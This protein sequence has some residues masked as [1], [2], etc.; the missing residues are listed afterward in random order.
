MGHLAVIGFGPGSVE[1]C[2]PEVVEILGSATDWVGYD[3]YLDM[4][5]TLVAP[6]PGAV[7]HRTDNRQEG[8]RAR[9]ALDLAAGG[10]SVAVVSSGDPGVFAMAAA[11]LE[12]IER[13]P[14]PA[15][16][17][18]VEITV[19][20]GISAAQAAAA[21]AGAPL[22]HDFCVLSLSDNLKPWDL[23]ER[24]LDAVAAADLVIALYNPRSRH[25]PDQIGKAV[26][27]IGRHRG[28]ATPVVLGRDVGRP[29]EQV[30]ITTLAQLAEPDGWAEVDMRTVIIVGSSQTRTIDGPGGRTLAYTSRHHP[31]SAPG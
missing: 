2:T 12:E 5:Q 23:V 11:V 4:A 25:R 28:G 9:A 20:P 8:E 19:H 13:E 27:I 31:G 3:T 7:L 21:R 30:R 6:A 15:R 14:D 26:A 17:G 24:R 29:D 1:W 22:G 18:E 10:R 16:W